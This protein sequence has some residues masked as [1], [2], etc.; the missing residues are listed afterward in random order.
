MR[1]K[2][3]ALLAQALELVA[4]CD[5]NA[6]IVAYIEPVWS[7]KDLAEAKQRLASNQPRYS[8]DEV[9]QHLRSLGAE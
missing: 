1:D 4:V 7:R 2:Q 9:L 6:D 3:A 8:T 5:P